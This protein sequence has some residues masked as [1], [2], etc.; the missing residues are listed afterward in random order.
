MTCLS[1]L[2]ALLAWGAHPMLA[3]AQGDL[4]FSDEGDGGDGGDAGDGEDGGDLNFDEP[5]PDDPGPGEEPGEE[6]EKSLAVLALP[7]E[8][9]EEGE[10]DKLQ[11]TLMKAMGVVRDYKISS[12]N[13]LVSAFEDEGPDECVKDALCIGGIGDDAKVDMILVARVNK[14]GDRYRLDVELFDVKERLFSSSAKRENLSNFNASVEQIEPAIKEVFDIRERRKG[15]KIEDPN[16]NAPLVQSI[17]AYTTAGLSAACLGGGIYFGLDA[18]SKYDAVL[19][20]P[21]TGDR[22]TDLTQRQAGELLGEARQV[23]TTA[24]IFYGLSVAL[25]ATSTALFLI[26][27]GSDIASEEELSSRPIRDLQVA[28][29]VSADGRMGMGAFFRF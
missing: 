22:Y 6:G 7:S 18:Q 15:P 29:T 26:D 10:R 11:S 5:D 13:E 27:F 8:G 21:K 25:A 3:H 2:I 17:F 1:V 24:N 4:D 16:K 28:P 23:A 14:R 19:N 9:L 20:R 12:G